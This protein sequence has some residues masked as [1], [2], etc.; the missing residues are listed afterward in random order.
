[1]GHPNYYFLP[2]LCACR[3]IKQFS[4]I[5]S[6]EKKT[7]AALRE[8]AVSAN[9]IKARKT[10][11][12]EKFYWFISS[13][14]YL[15]IAGRDGQQNELLVKRYMAPNDIYVHADLHGASSV[16]IKNPSGKEVQHFRQISLVPND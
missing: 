9:I 6:A 15:V 14:N 8:V 2:L 5:K 12:F 4:A 16:V 3:N 7:K 10:F 11:W 13:E 1:M